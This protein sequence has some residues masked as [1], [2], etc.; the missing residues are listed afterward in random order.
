MINDTDIDDKIK[1]EINA[2]NREHVENF[3]RFGG[4]SIEFKNY[5]REYNKKVDK[6]YNKIKNG[7]R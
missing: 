2:L 6:L 5:K 4:N 3:V 7:R 1:E